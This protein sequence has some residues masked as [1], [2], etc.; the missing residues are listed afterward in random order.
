MR[1]DHPF[2]RYPRRPCAVNLAL[3]EPVVSPAAAEP[4]DLR[5]DTVTRPTP[6][7]RAAIAAA[8][9][10]DDVFD[11]DPTIHA[12]QERVAALAGKE[13]A[14]FVPSGTMGNQL[15]VRLQVDHGDE[16]LLERDCHIFNYEP[17]GAAALS[18]AQIQPL[19]GARGAL[20]PEAV[21][22][23]IRTPDVHHAPTRLLCLENTHNRAGG[24][25]VP[26]EALT[27]TAEA[28]RGRGLRVHLD[29]ARLWNASVATGI[30]IA[31]WAA[32]FDTV[33]MCF[34][35]GLGAPV[36]SI[37]VGEAAVIARARRYR[38]MLGGGMRQAGMLAAACLHALDHHVDRLADD[39]R[40]ARRLAEL[41]AKAPGLA[42]DPA[43]VDTNIVLL[44][45]LEPAW[46]APRVVA[47]LAARG[48]RM[49]PFGPRTVRAVTH[50]DIDDDAI[51]RA[52][53]GLARLAVDGIQATV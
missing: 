17:G 20:T 52:G 7:M 10:G 6:A 38:K 51:E 31:R 33:M 29:G 12:L 39:H 27:A 25:I 34:S 40:R 35:K 21:V 47:A 8:P 44:E 24:A 9:V 14:L 18:G 28:A 13:A 48:I 22:A 30:P 19:V 4:V 46:D 5:S 36:G 1:A 45:V 37:L 32:P 42:C 53:A 43:R 15:A 26:L 16:V 2:G 23:A 49:V 11:D 3:P 50:L 41:A